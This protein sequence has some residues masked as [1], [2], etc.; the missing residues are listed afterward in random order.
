MTKASSRS[1]LLAVAILVV[2]LTGLFMVLRHTANHTLD[3]Q[4]ATTLFTTEHPFCDTVPCSYI[5]S[6]LVTQPTSSL[7]VVVLALQYLLAG[8]V[9]L[10]NAVKDGG[11]A[12]KN[13]YRGCLP[14]PSDAPDGKAR[15]WWAYA[16]LVWGVSVVFA[17]VSF[18]AFTF[19]LRCTGDPHGDAVCL[20]EKYDWVAQTYYILQSIGI[21]LFV[22]ARSYR[23]MRKHTE[24]AK[25]YVILHSGLYVLCVCVAPPLRGYIVSM[26]FITPS[27]VVLRMIN[28]VCLGDKILHAAWTIMSCSF[29]WYLAWIAFAPY[30]RWWEETGW[31]FSEN[32]ALHLPLVLFVPLAY[33]SVRKVKDK[34]AGDGVTLTETG[35]RLA[36]PE[37]S[38]LHFLIAATEET[39]EGALLTSKV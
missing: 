26:V 38:P 25:R 19:Q 29:L 10:Y 16:F 4:I 30:G 36:A 24:M 18:Q 23:A 33:V 21:D 27:F 6:T 28:F 8:A 7:L 13:C 2:C 3:K 1:A 11:W 32:D 17:G 37:W 14:A 39:E 34:P 12:D 15:V 35:K 22:V 20:H 5:G 31:W 9:V